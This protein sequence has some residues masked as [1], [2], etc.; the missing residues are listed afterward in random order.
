MDIHCLCF[1][2]SCQSLTRVTVGIS[3]VLLACFIALLTALPNEHDCNCGDVP[4]YNNT[5]P[6]TPP[7]H[8]AAGL[9]Y[10]IAVITDLDTE[11]KLEGNLCKNLLNTYVYA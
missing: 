7:L 4:S 6:L 5:Y 1:A 2:E 3:V 10:R 8:T 11:S 9:V